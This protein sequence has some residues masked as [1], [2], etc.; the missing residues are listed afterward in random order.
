[1]GPRTVIFPTQSLSELSASKEKTYGLIYDR[2][3]SKGTFLD[4]W[5]GGNLLL[6][7]TQPKKF[8]GNS[9]QIDFQIPKET[10]CKNDLQGNSRL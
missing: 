2:I 8:T 3:H 7:K 10:V 9:F 6:Q 5:I 4:P 1:M